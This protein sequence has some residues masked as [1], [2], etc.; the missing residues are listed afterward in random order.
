MANDDDDYESI[1]MT[2]FQFQYNTPIDI[3]WL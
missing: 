1:R 3:K 2:A